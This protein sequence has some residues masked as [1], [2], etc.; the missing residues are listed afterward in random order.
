MNCLLHKPHPSFELKVMNLKEKRARYSKSVMIL[1]MSVYYWITFNIFI[2][3]EN[4]VFGIILLI[5]NL[6]LSEVSPLF[7]VRIT[8]P[9][10]IFLC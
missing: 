3:M 6:L 8:I 1:S 2:E 9:F 7:S 5:T 4:Q 10:I